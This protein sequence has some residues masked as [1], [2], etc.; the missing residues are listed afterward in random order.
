MN[1]LFFA[2]IAEFTK[3]NKLEITNVS[4]ID[5]LKHILEGKYPALK[6]MK[7]SIAVNQQIIHSNEQISDK[8][9]VALLP[10]FSG[11]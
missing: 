1:V 3:T 10:P 9:E 11:G 7:Y 5:E 4:N 6:E 2:S 8:D